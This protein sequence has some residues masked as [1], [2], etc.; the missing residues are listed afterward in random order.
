M[1]ETDGRIY[2]MLPIT[3]PFWLTQSVN[4]SLLLNTHH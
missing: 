2:C 3:L 1:R 4:S